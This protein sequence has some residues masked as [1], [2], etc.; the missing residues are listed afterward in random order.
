[1]PS[2]CRKR[3]TGQNRWVTK[4]GQVSTLEM[5]NIGVN[6]RNDHLNSANPFL[7][8]FA[9]P[10]EVAVDAGCLRTILLD[11]QELQR[12]FGSNGS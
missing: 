5:V 6:Q 1:M 4:I 2:L 3:S 8:C 7:R 9:A 12:Y 10:T 11:V